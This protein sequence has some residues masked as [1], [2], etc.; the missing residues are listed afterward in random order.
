MLSG[1]GASGAFGL[2][3]EEEGRE[4]EKMRR[5]A[6]SGSSSSGGSLRMQTL[7][8]GYEHVPGTAGGDGT[9][10]FDVGAESDEE[11]EMEKG[12]SG[13]QAVV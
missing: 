9:T 10:V 5:T 4:G 1:A 6:S 12:R 8:G 2:R 13:H 11:D 7:R 3:L